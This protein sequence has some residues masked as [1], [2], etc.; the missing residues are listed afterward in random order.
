MSAE[1]SAHSAAELERSG[2]VSSNWPVPSNGLIW[3]FETS[4]AYRPHTR[5]WRW[6]ARCGGQIR[7]GKWQITEAEAVAAALRAGANHVRG[8]HQTSTDAKAHC[9]ECNELISPRP[10]P[11]MTREPD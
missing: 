2:V 8:G 10:S 9:G 11:Q 6:I 5:R 3:V 4:Y 1:P 7:R